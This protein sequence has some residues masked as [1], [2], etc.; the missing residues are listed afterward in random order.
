V[1]CNGETISDSEIIQE[2]VKGMK[3][4]VKLLQF[5]RRNQNPD[6]ERKKRGRPINFGVIGTL[7]VK[8][9]KVGNGVCEPKARNPILRLETVTNPPDLTDYNFLKYKNSEQKRGM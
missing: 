1:D 8:N 3:D 7:T 5:E 4:Y 6:Y 9:H 2:T